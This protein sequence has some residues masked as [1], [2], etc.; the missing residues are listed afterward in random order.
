MATPFKS[1][2]DFIKSNPISNHS[3]RVIGNWDNRP[4]YKGTVSPSV[5]TYGAQSLNSQSAL[6]TAVVTNVGAFGLP[7][8]SITSV[9]DWIVSNNCPAVL[10]PGETC[11]ISAVFNPK[12]AGLHTGGIYVN[13]GDAAGTEFVELMGVG[14]GSAVVPPVYPTLSISDGVILPL[15]SSIIAAYPSGTTAL[16]T[17]AFETDVA[18]GSTATAT[19]RLVSTGSVTYGTLPTTVG[20]FLIQYGEV[21]APVTAPAT[22]ADGQSLRVALTYQPTAIGAS[23]SILGIVSNSGTVNL[24]LTGNAVSNAAN[25]PPT[26]TGVPT[27]PQDIVIGI[28]A[29]LDNFVIADANGDTL[30]ATLTTNNGTIN[31]LTDA[32][33]TLAGIQLTGTAAQ[34]TAAIAAATFTA[35]AVGNA[36]IGISVTDGVNPPVTAGYSFVAALTASLARITIS[37]NQFIRN[38]QPFR[39]KAVNW[40]GFQSNTLCVHG[41]WRREWKSMMTDLVNMGFN[42]IRLPFSREGFEQVRTPTDLGALG[43]GQGPGATDVN[44]DWMGK[45]NFELLTM[46]IDECTARGVYVILDHHSNNYDSLTGTPID[47]YWTQP[48][49]LALW[50]EMATRYGSNTTIIGA[51]LF[52]EPWATPW[53]TLRTLFQT[54][55]NHIHTIA[56]DWLIFCGGGQDSANTFWHGGNLEQVSTLPVTL[57]IANRVAYAP[58]EYGHSVGG[59]SWLATSG[60]T[61]ANWPLNLNVKRRTVW[62]YIFEE[63]I[64]PVLVGE[65]GGKFGWNND[66]TASGDGNAPF[67]RVWLD[68]LIDHMNG[69]FDGNGTTNLTS[70][71]TGMSYAYWVFNANSGDTGGLLIDNTTWSPVFQEKLDL[72][73]PLLNAVPM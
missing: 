45:T 2:L 4:R 22:L 43:V 51:D 31:G 71:Q 3:S 36:N 44:P 33:L 26:I 17:Y 66:G 60:N 42:A 54:C 69:D 40:A 38:G 72:I 56:P 46:F 59:Q 6:Q 25:V 47:S 9:G 16:T 73:E 65:F 41:L 37:G 61:P 15:G 21:G 10:Q 32:N 11:Q 67:E 5:M 28:A 20:A 52:N 39:I 48:G 13:T 23:S 34:I 7:I 68:N 29:P 14:Q 1:F 27:V 30:T 58:H 57:A 49:W 53:S 35:T 12:R 19:L 24:T 18:V 55:G 8:E 63:G 62:S 70:N 50:G 64:A